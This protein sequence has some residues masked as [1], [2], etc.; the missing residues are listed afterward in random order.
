VLDGVDHARGRC[1]V[2]GSKGGIAPADRL[3]K[4]L[5]IKLPPIAQVNQRS[6][7]AVIG[8]QFGCLQHEPSFTTRR[9]L[10]EH[11]GEGTLVATLREGDDRLSASIVMRIVHAGREGVAD[12]RAVD[13]QL[14]PQ[15]ALRDTGES[16]APLCPPAP[17]QGI[18]SLRRGLW[19]NSTHSTD[20]RTSREAAAP[21]APSVVVERE[22]KQGSEQQSGGAQGLQDAH[23]GQP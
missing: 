9:E 20:A 10:G 13:D 7:Q 11:S 18:A 19:R 12:H 4:Q 3:L 22:L 23:T 5:A 21:G 14:G 2:R 17:A 1:L 8:K 6:K 16:I 15:P